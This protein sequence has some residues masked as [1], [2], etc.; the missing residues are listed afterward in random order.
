MLL[1]QNLA[2]LPHRRVS[3]S[4]WVFL[5]QRNG[6]MM[7]SSSF[8]SSNLPS[9]IVQAPLI[10][11]SAFHFFPPPLN[12]DPP[13]DTSA[14]LKFCIPLRLSHSPSHYRAISAVFI[15]YHLSRFLF[16]YEFSVSGIIFGSPF[17]VSNF[18][19]LNF[20]PVSPLSSAPSNP[21]RSRP[22]VF[23]PLP[24]EYQCPAQG[25]LSPRITWSNRCFSGPHFPFNTPR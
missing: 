23:R 17:A 15:S 16:P 2:F 1:V 5:P 3:P 11:F 10:F 6:W 4:T 20:P 22:Q 21:V 25:P 13:L 9:A 24:R 7:G 19:T 8:R 18:F 12:S 14:L